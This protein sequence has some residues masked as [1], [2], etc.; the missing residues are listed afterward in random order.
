MKSTLLQ[1]SSHK[2]ITVFFVAAFF[3]SCFFAGAALYDFLP[4]GE[5][6][7]EQGAEFLRADSDLSL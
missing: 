2:L 5:S 7:R 1:L 3:T 4:K 6:D